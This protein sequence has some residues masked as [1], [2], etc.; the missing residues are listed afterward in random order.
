MVSVAKSPRADYNNSRDSLIHH[1][2]LGFPCQPWAAGDNQDRGVAGRTSLAMEHESTWLSRPR[3]L[4]AWALGLS[5]L[6]SVFAVFRGGYVGPDY[7]T[8]LARILNDLR[9]F[10]FSMGDPPLYILLA[11]GLYKLIGRNNG[12]PITMAILQAV[13]NTV[14]MWWFFLYSE[15]RFKSPVLHLAFVFFLSFLPV[16]IIHSVT[17]GTDWMT[18]PVFVLLLFVFDRFRSEDTSTSKNAALIGLILALGIWSKYNFMALLPAIFVIFLF[19]WRKRRWSLKRFV[20]ICALGLVLPTA[21]LVYSY[22]ESTRATNAASQTIW[23]PKGGA[24]GQPETD[25]KDLLWVKAADVQLFSA[26]EFYIRKPGDSYYAGLRTPHRHSFLALSH[27]GTF[28]DTQNIFQDLPRAQAVD[29]FL[30][31]DYKIRRPWK[32]SVMVASM[33]LGVLWT[34]LAIIGTLWMVLS[35]AIR[36]WRDKLEREHVAI[37]LGTAFYL[38]MFLLIPFL[39]GTAITGSWASRLYLVPLLCFFWAGFRL[40]DRT[41]VA[42]W[43]KIAF[44][45]LTLVIVQCGIVIVMLA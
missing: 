5:F 22:W 40:L 12:F 38:L 6:V 1:D 8:H 29:H 21:L 17:N 11:H 3:V 20:M 7:N 36:L 10:D 42:K 30:I 24:P 39:A 25:W 13:I 43:P 19:L 27:M 16:R 18:I 41:V 26:P 4:W 32:T 45:V 9:F 37:L 2:L 28:T 33:S 15:R 44:D 31:P 23:I 14:A 35:A 34:V